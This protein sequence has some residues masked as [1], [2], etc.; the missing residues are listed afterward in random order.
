MRGD[1]AGY[2]TT[3]GLFQAVGYIHVSSMHARTV[4]CLPGT[5]LYHY[6]Y[7][8]T[9]A[10]GKTSIAALLRLHSSRT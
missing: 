2:N 6:Y 10:D 1:H 9:A 7:C 4:L 3:P 8:T 5:E